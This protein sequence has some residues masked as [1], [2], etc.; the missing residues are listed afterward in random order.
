MP[1]RFSE[2]VRMYRNRIRKPQAD[3]LALLREAAH[4]VVVYQYQ[5]AAVGRRVQRSSMSNHAAAEGQCVVCRRA[6]ATQRHHIIPI[7]RGG[8][9]KK[10]N[11]VPVC[12]TCHRRIHAPEQEKEGAS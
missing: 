9:S 2:A 4:K 10:A 3:V 6:K 5:P 7:S 12:A 8:R 11:I 1:M